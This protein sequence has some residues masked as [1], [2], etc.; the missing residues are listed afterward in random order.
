MLFPSDSL[1]VI[2]SCTKLTQ[3][4]V[5]RAKPPGGRRPPS[6]LLL[7]EN[8]KI[9]AKYFHFTNNCVTRQIPDLIDIT[10]D[11][12]DDEEEKEGK[13]EKEESQAGKP[14]VMK[15]LDISQVKLR[16]T[17][18]TLVKRPT[19]ATD[20]TT[21]PKSPVPGWM[22]EL[23]K[24]QANRRSVGNFIDQNSPEEPPPSLPPPPLPKTSQ[25]TR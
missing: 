11:Q 15:M 20:T 14:F 2:G 19:T 23:S 12:E 8:V 24:K 4:T 13:E 3:P 17:K 22:E 25:F 1:D 5:G 7:R 16:E 18:P 21:D 10:L 9:I 6:K